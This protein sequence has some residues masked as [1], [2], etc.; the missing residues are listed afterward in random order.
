M[1]CLVAIYR[2]DKEHCYSLIEAHVS[3]LNEIWSDIKQT[4]NEIKSHEI[5]TLYSFN[6]HLLDIKKYS[7][8]VTNGI[9]WI[10]YYVDIIYEDTVI[11][12]KAYHKDY[13]DKQITCFKERY[14]TNA[15]NE[16][17]CIDDFINRGVQPL[18]DNINDLVDSIKDRLPERQIA[19]E[20]HRTF[21]YERDFTQISMIRKYAEKIA[22]NCNKQLER[23]SEFYT[24]L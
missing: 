24:K 6:S 13:R 1:K 3:N 14:I 15:K 11:I 8:N 12:M 21:C 4:I 19:I 17:N 22:E 18:I 16:G 9:E 2:N 23:I 20:Y 5:L 10:D 7:N